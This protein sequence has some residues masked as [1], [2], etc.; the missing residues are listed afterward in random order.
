MATFCK[1]PVFQ[2][3]HIFYLTHLLTVWDL[4]HKLTDFVKKETSDIPNFHFFKIGGLIWS[5]KKGNPFDIDQKYGE[6][7][8]FLETCRRLCIGGFN[9]FEVWGLLLVVLGFFFRP[10]WFGG[11]PR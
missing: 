8:D 10:L 5:G 7:Q 6:T 11:R 4:E 9:K 1:L 2:E 3:M